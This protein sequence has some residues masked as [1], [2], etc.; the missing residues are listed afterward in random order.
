[1]VKLP[2]NLGHVAFQV[3]QVDDSKS[4]HKKWLF[5]QTSIE[6]NKKMLLGY[7]GVVFQPSIFVKGRIDTLVGGGRAIITP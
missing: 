6:T 2:K 1:M 3:F 4:L 7:Q 5:Y